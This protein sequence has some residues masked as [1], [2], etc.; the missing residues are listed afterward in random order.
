[1]TTFCDLCHF[2]ILQVTVMSRFPKKKIDG[3]SVIFLSP[4]G[5]R[6]S[7]VKFPL[8]LFIQTDFFML[9]VAESYV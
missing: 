9:L 7:V 5:K 4:C 8:N 1:M 6:E 2:I 3:V